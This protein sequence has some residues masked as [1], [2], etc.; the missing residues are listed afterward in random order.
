[1]RLHGFIHE[2]FEKL[3]FIE[4]WTKQQGIEVSFT[5]MYEDNSTFPDINDYDGLIIMGGT[6]S[7]N[8]DLEWIRTERAHIQAAIE[9]GKPVLGVCFGS[10]QIAQV[11]GGSVGPMGQKEIGF[12]DIEF[13]QDFKD[14]LGVSEIPAKQ[15]HWH[16]ERV[17]LPES[18]DVKLIGKSACCPIQ[19]FVHGDNVVGIQFHQEMGKATIDELLVNCI[20]EIEEGGEHVQTQAQIE[21]L[22]EPHVTTDLIYAILQKIF[23][24]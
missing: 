22:I 18:A 4:T 10:Q 14:F 7:T 9:T 6:M 8:D 23:K 11:L 12:H 3:A 13:T 15:F 20:Q 17:F 1:M 19:G 16:G 21:S 2:R 24:K 5:F